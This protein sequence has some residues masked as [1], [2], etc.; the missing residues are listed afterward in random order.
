MGSEGASSSWSELLVK[1]LP[2]RAGLACEG[3]TCQQA[4]AYVVVESSGKYSI[5]D[6][7]A[8]IRREQGMHSVVLEGRASIEESVEN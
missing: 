8:D 5:P 7:L 6:A 2:I 4:R 3:R 1:P